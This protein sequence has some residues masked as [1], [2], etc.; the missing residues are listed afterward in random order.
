MSLRRLL[1]AVAILVASFAAIGPTTPVQAAAKD[2]VIIVP[3]F[4]TGDLVS[5]G[6][7]PQKWRL[8]AQ[9][10]DVTLLTKATLAQSNTR[11][12]QGGVAVVIDETSLDL[13]NGAEVDFVDDLIGASFKIKNPNAVAS[14]GCGTSFTI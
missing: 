9:G 8:E 11:Y 10:Y 5:V 13:L 7:Y 3:G 2:P 1:A 14:C 4:T 6:Y 12:A